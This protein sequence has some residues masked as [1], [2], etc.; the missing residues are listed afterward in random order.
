[1]AGPSRLAIMNHEGNDVHGPRTGDE[2]QGE[3]HD[4]SRTTPPARVPMQGRAWRLLLGSLLALTVAESPGLRAGARSPTASAAYFPAG[5]GP[6]ESS[7][8]CLS[9]VEASSR[10]LDL[11]AGE[12]VKLTT[13]LSVSARETIVIKDLNDVVVRRLVDRCRDPGSYED[14]WDGRSDIGARLQDGQYRWVATLEDGLSSIT[15]D[16]SHELDGDSE[17]KSHPEYPN[18]SPFDNVPLSFSHTFDRPG[19]IVLVFSRDTYYVTLKCDPPKFFCRF[20]DGYQPSGDFS[21]EWAGVD[22]SGAF[23][24]DIHAVFVISHHEQLSANAIVV[25]HGAPRISAVTVSPSAYLPFVGRQEVAFN[26]SSFPRER[27]SA[28]LTFVNQETRSALRRIELRDV[29][30]GRVTATW[31]G[32]GDNGMQVAPGPYTVTVTATDSLGQVAR[33]EILTRVEY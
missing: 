15:I 23:R 11:Q 1:M 5:C 10:E 6:T 3:A 25:H 27:L 28:I 29:A 21:Y 8:I 19:E 18:W 31:D 13:L 16:R 12:P 9:T 7:V 32:R 22:D 33:G 14:A 4:A 24:P 26:I 17:V 2:I 30:P 20:L